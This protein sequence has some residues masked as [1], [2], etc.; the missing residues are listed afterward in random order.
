M[1]SHL[2]PPLANSIY[3]KLR[4]VMICSNTNPPVV[5]R[6]IV[7]AVR[8]T[9]SISQ[10]GKIIGLYFLWFTFWLVFG[11]PLAKRPINS[12]FLVSTEITG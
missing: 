5:V 9:L 6:N 1:L 7:N 12:F 8:N 11:S 3:S 4:C 10:A 2:V